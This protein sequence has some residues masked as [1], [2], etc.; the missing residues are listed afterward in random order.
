MNCPSAG[1]SFL[2]EAASALE[3]VFCAPPTGMLYTIDP[4]CMAGGSSGQISIGN[5]KSHA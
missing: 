1:F 5:S 4:Q 2:A 3:P